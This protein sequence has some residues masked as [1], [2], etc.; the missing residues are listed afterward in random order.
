MTETT[1]SDDD[2]V[3]TGMSPSQIQR[4]EGN[5]FQTNYIKGDVGEKVA[6]TKIRETGLI[7]VKSGIDMREY[8]REILFEQGSTD[9]RI[10]A[11]KIPLDEIPDEAIEDFQ[12]KWD[13][14]SDLKGKEVTENGVDSLEREFIETCKADIDEYE[15]QYFEPVGNVEVKLKTSDTWYGRTNTRHHLKF[16]RLSQEEDIPTAM[17]F[18]EFRKGNVNEGACIRDNLVVYDDDKDI[19]TIAEDVEADDQI[20]YEITK[21]ENDADENDVVQYDESEYIHWGNFLFEMAE[22]SDNVG[23]DRGV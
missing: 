11:P 7:P 19:D 5:D 10:Y 1:E 20:D 18:F 16:S 17:W 4:K 9:F 15:D 23:P 2:V 21:D 6:A 8:Q 12:F 14:Y 3:R 13:R 22:H